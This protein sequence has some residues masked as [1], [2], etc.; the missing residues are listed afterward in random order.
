MAIQFFLVFFGSILG[1]AIALAIAAKNIFK[2][3]AVTGKK[4]FVYGLLSSI[5]T[6]LAAYLTSYFSTDPFTIFWYL[7]GIFLLFGIFHILFT[8]KRYFQANKY[9]SNK[10]LMAE[11]VFGLSVIL[12]TIVIFSSLQYFLLKNTQ[13]L[14]FPLLMSSILFF[15]PLLFFHSFQA[16]VNIP[17]TSFPTWQYPL[18]KPIELPDSDENPGERIVVIGFEIAKKATDARKTYFRAKGP[19]TMKLGD[20]FYHFM[21]EYNEQYSETQIEY[22]DLAYEPHEWWFH[23]HSKWYQAQRIYNPDLS[24]RENGIKEN[25]VIICERVFDPVQIFNKV[26]QHV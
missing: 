11:I 16:V 6:T 15:V 10:I 7:G 13:F 23:R 8:H 2:G 20:F 25:T 17:A 5:V 1:C 12:F 3:F 19:E 4:P 14:F 24:T 9:N 18:H 22:T 26:Q 21:N